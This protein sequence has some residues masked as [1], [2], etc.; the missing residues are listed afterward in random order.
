MVIWK[1]RLSFS[2]YVE[3]RKALSVPMIRK[4]EGGRRARES[5]GGTRKREAWCDL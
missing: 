4:K 5:S 1:S 2:M 3:R